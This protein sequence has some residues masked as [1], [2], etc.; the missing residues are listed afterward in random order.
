MLVGKTL[1]WIA[2]AG[3]RVGRK[4]SVAM[5]APLRRDG[6][7]VALCGVFPRGD[8]LGDAREPGDLGD[9]VFRRRAEPGREPP[10]RGRGVNDTR[11]TEMPRL[12]SIA[13]TFW[14]CFSS[15]TSPPLL[16]VHAERVALIKSSCGLPRRSGSDANPRLSFKKCGR[17]RN[18]NQFYES[19]LIKI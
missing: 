1:R 18:H 10:V 19:T 6:D 8:P 12:K 14:G 5:D 15:R 2:R 16:F 9:R 17:Y 13:S 7:P 3:G 11:D 4:A